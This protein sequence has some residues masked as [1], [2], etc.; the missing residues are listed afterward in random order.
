MWLEEMTWLWLPIVS[1]IGIWMVWSTLALK[2]EVRA[3]RQ[4]LEPWRLERPHAAAKKRPPKAGQAVSGTERG[5]GLG[6]PML[7][8]ASR[9]FQG[10]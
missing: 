8:H 3:L 1:G 10:P 9:A 2:T 6:D 4:R 5:V 7:L